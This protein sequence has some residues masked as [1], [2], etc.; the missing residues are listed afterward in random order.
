MKDDDFLVLAGGRPYSMRGLLVMNG[1]GMA[2][3]EVE[4]LKALRPGE[5][6]EIPITEALPDGGVQC[7][8]ILIERPR[9]PQA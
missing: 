4:Q 5:S 2:Y 3:D 8:H 9:M 1:E 6:F 7:S